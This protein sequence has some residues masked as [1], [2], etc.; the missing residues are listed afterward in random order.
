MALTTKPANDKNDN[1]KKTT[2]TK[3]S[4]DTLLAILREFQIIDGE[5]PIQYAI[6][7]LEI[8][9]EEGRSLTYLSEKTGMPLSTVSRIIGALSEHRQ[10]GQPFGLVEVQ[11][12]KIERRRKELCLTAKGKAIVERLNLMMEA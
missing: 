6:C 12:S 10:K 2:G 8:S 9:R 1:V 5:F 11:T 4:T 7:L 3:K